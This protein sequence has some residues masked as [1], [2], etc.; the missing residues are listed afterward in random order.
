MT[1]FEITRAMVRYGGS[2]TSRLGQL[3]QA[4]DP[5]NQAR[6]KAAFPEYWEKYAELAEMQSRRKARDC[7]EGATTDSGNMDYHQA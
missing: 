2:F 1:D 3:F 6:L 7:G 5:D 4:G